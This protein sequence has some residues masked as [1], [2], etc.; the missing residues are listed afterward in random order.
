LD[1]YSDGF[2]PAFALRTNASAKSFTVATSSLEANV[3]VVRLFVLCTT[4]SFARFPAL[5]SRVVADVGSCTSAGSPDCC[6]NHSGATRHSQ[7]TSGER[8]SAK[9]CEA[10]RRSCGPAEGSTRYAQSSGRGRCPNRRSRNEAPYSADHSTAENRPDLY[11]RRLPIVPFRDFGEPTR[12][13]NAS[14]PSVP[15]K[16][17][18]VNPL[19]SKRDNLSVSQFTVEA[20]FRRSVD[21]GL[22]IIF[23]T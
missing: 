22:P 1:T 12:H 23:A 13:F 2:S 3:L 19:G 10:R 8:T 20:N 21:F 5:F 9:G 15:T 14:T 16:Q 17:L 6:T 18:G 11:V 7:S 4:K